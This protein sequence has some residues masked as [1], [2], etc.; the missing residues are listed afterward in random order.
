VCSC[1]NCSRS[2]ETASASDMVLCICSMQVTNCSL[3]AKPYSRSTIIIYAIT[4][5]QKRLFQGFIISLGFNFTT[6]ICW[7][8][9]S[10]VLWIS[11]QVAVFTKYTMLLKA[12]GG[13]I[14]KSCFLLRN[15]RRFFSLLSSFDMSLYLSGRCIL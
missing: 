4:N 13:S 8:P 1:C 7:F 6:E 15:H 5:V 14:C 10:W 12:K 9:A 2:C 11:L 3:N